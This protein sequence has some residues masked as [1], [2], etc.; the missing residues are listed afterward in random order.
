MTRFR[1]WPAGLAR[2][3]LAVV[4]AMI[5]L[6]VVLSAMRPIG[7]DRYMADD[8]SKSDGALYQAVAERVAMGEG[9]YQAAIAEHRLRGY[10]L[11]PFVTV[12]PPATA[13]II[14]AIGPRLASVLQTI[15]AVAVV[16][17]GSLSLRGVFDGRLAQA[18]AFACMVFGVVFLTGRPDLV[19]WHEVWAALLVAL[20]LNCRGEGRYVASVLL[21]LAAV[22]IR[23][24]AL[25]YLLVMAFAALVERRRA[26][27][28]AWTV[29]A[30]VALG[31]IAAHAMEVSRLVLATDASSPGWASFGGW[32]L[33]LSM[34]HAT[35][36]LSFMPLIVT[37]FVVPLALLGWGAWCDPMGF[38]GFLLMAGYCCGF[39]AIGRADNIYWGLLLAP[40]LFIGLA[41]A[42]AALADLLRAAKPR[43]IGFT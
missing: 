41:F 29:G 7:S 11:K 5:A 33:V 39:M 3:V 17:A 1:H 12:R 10:P 43:A 15:L 32:N 40:L 13:W 26:E 34:V 23:E 19:Y 36:A 28:L 30:L 20:S 6:G 16:V 24:L 31:C 27:A 35:S 38:R 14:A 18:G 22:V 4:F 37:A 8:P 9:Y 42:P 25:P 2:A 21:G